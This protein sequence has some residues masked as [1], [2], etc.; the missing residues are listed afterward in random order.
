MK[1][2]I[3]GESQGPHDTT[4][5][6]RSVKAAAYIGQDAPLPSIPPFESKSTGKRILT[7]EAATYVAPRG[8][9]DRK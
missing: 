2:V 5:D 7:T 8:Q 1:F 6:E 9:D 3:S 4:A